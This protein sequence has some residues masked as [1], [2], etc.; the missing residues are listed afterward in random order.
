L[1]LI[2]IFADYTKENLK[3][4]PQRITFSIDSFDA[5]GDCYEKGVYLHFGNTA[6]RVCESPKDIADIEEQISHLITEIKEAI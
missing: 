6:V 4:E 3:M 5:D 2:V 1:K